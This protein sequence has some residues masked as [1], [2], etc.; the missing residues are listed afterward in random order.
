[1]ISPAQQEA[2]YKAH[3]FNIIRVVL[4]KQL[5][6][7]GEAD[8]RYVR[9]ASTLAKWIQDGVLVKGDS[10]SLTI[11]QMEFE[12]PEGGRRTLDGLVVLVKVDDYGKGRVLPHEKTYLGPKQDQLNLL[13]ACRANLTPIHTV[14]NDPE[15]WVINQYRP[16][17][18]GPPEQEVIDTDGIIHRTWAL[19]DVQTIARIRALLI[20]K[21]LFIADGHHRYETALAYRNEVRRSGRPPAS[22]G[23]EY[24][25]MYITSTSH[26]GLT[27]LPAHRMVKS[28]EEFNV[29]QTVRK[30]EPYFEIEE[31]DLEG[32]DLEKTAAWL[33]ARVSSHSDRAGYF[34]MLVQGE[35]KLRLLRLRNFRG[36]DSMIDP[37]I[38][39]PLRDLDVTILREIVMDYGL[40]MDK[41]DLQQRIEY[42]P[43]VEE[44][45]KRVCSGEMQVSFILNPTRVQQVQA[46]ARL[47]H[48]LPH[49][50][51]Y[52]YPKIMS[53][54]VLN[55]F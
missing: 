16:F 21:S 31:A 3:Q 54:L 24:V 55:V 50:S 47:G 42:T 10:E 9:A 44:A 34:G 20:D 33:L 8:N 7:D 17:M 12:A 14:F 29:E 6:G 11:Y 37:E 25:M 18:S 40:G 43:S 49:K 15:N 30:L 27:I 51:T 53:G 28:L 13:R 36:I 35:K 32:E 26:P 23:H 1:V 22:D 52:F 38:P 41:E 19:G 45:L 5:P 4:G 48:R 46:A 2:Y 39:G